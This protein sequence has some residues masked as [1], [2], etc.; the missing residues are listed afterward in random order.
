M[1]TIYK[2]VLVNYDGSEAE[3]NIFDVLNSVN[4]EM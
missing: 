2:V 3:G 1:G 4:E